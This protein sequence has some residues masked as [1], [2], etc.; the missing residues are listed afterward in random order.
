MAYVPLPKAMPK[1][2]KIK[3]GVLKPVVV[4]SVVTETV[5]KPLPKV[6]VLK[7]EPVEEK[8][9]SAWWWVLGVAA[10]ALLI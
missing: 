8:S 3:P 4:D 7:S 5:T 9:S 6:E 1:K 2:V 10:L